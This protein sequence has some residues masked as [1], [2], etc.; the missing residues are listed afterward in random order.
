MG[1]RNI[2]LNMMPTDEALK[3]Y[4]EKLESSIKI[5]ENEK[6]SVLNSRGRVT[7]NAIFARK[8]SPLYDSAAMDGIAVES[9]NTKDAR[10]SNPIVLT[11]DK[12]VIVDTGDPVLPPF[13]TVIMAEDLEIKDNDEIMIRSSSSPW[14][15]IR[16][17]GEDIVQG[18]MILPSSHKIRSIDI[19]VLLSGGVTE[20]EVNKLTK[21]AIFPTGTEM[22]E[23]S[24]EPELGQIIES[25]SRMFEAMVEENGGK[26]CRFSAVYDDYDL[27]KEVIEQAID[28]F[29]MIIINAG[30][31]AG[32]ED[33][34]ANVLREIGEVVVH[35]VAIK[36]GKPVILAIVK[37][38]PVIGLPGY[39]VSAYITY[40]KFV[41]PILEMM[42]NI[43]ERDS[44]YL[45]ATL[46]RRV[47]SSIKH[48]E[49]V[50]VKVGKVDDSYVAVPLARGAGAAMSLVKADG[51]C[52]IK[53]NI[54]GIEAGEKVK[55]LLNKSISKLSKTLVSIGS[56]DLILDL[57]SD[58]MSKEF[59]GIHLSSSHVGSMAGLMSLRRGEAHIAPIHILN[60]KSSKYNI[61]IVNEIFPDIRMSLIKGVGRVQ[62]I[63]VEKGNPYNIKN[64]KDLTKVKYINR[65]RGAGTRIMF[66]FQLKENGVDPKN[67]VGYEREAATHMAV[68]T[69]IKNG[70]ANAGMGILSAAKAMDLDF[71]P[72]ANEEY[73]FALPTK[74]LELDHVKSFIKILKSKK[75]KERVEELGGYS[76]D[77]TGETINLMVY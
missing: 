55:V 63:M 39:P 48:E 66:D 36:P 76:L 4:K 7:S 9:E 75:F 47:V 41:V 62:G 74:N 34:T 69:A 68:A 31:S 1:K 27:L 8:N 77:S 73:D 45:E 12:Y 53:E 30:S 17:V 42:G 50:R 72:I 6:I 29:D 11:K 10:E 56:H 58:L 51:F 70:S 67:I 57:I 24:E 46:A 14:Q 22:V 23:P 26:P 15:H 33:Y 21:V 5:P 60:E 13:N 3:L 71:I 49:Y 18:E 38:K 2:Y 52:I 59:T 19:G 61:E 64:I 43:I 25:N 44:D 54:E 32:T 40:E 65:Q 16:P 35:G 20:I 37:G 28:D